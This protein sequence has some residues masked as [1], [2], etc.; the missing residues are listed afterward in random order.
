[1]LFFV[2][3]S[4]KYHPKSPSPYAVLAAIS[5]A[6]HK[7]RTFHQDVFQ[8]KRDLCKTLYEK[9]GQ[10]NPYEIPRDFALYKK[11]KDVKFG[12][13]LHTKGESEERYVKVP[14][15]NVPG[16][17]SNMS[18]FEIKGR[19]LLNP[20]IV[21]KCPILI[22]KIRELLNIAASH[23]C[24]VFASISNRPP[25]TVNEAQLSIWYQ[26]LIERTNLMCTECGLTPPEAGIL[27]F[28]ETDRVADIKTLNNFW[29][30]TFG[31]GHGREWQNI[32]L[33][34]FADSSCTP[35]IEL[36]DVVAYILNAERQPRDDLRDLYTRVRRLSW[37][38]INQGTPP[39]LKHGIRIFSA[40]PAE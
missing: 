3:E 17:I 4:G 34:L 26:R 18:D 15:H 8:Y 37:E 16:T 36:A 40:R 31:H 11:G 32:Q 28:D 21:R 29:R 1:M 13:D 10:L 23:Q 9:L 2:D 12:R 5:L 27:V 7:A 24:K 20:D 25:D 14:G 38:S 33:V 39:H 22:E 30:Y 6:N 19:E 35:G